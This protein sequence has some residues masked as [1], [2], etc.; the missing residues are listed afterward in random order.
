MEII[1][2]SEN[3]K[4]YLVEGCID[5]GLSKEAI[6]T[7]KLF[8]EVG[9]LYLDVADDGM[10]QSCKTKQQKIVEQHLEDLKNSILNWWAIE[11]IQEQIEPQFVALVK[12]YK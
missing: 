9:P 3:S 4:E 6:D 5:A 2:Y 1:I 10:V 7:F 11:G 8:N 12:S